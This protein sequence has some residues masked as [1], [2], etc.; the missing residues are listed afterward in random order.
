MSETEL[1]QVLP[2]ACIPCCDLWRFG[3]LTPNK[4]QAYKRLEA[5]GRLRIAHVTLYRQSGHTVVEYWSSL[6]HAWMLEELAACARESLKVQTEQQL[7]M[8]GENE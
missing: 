1:M 6:P 8:K 2:P 3:D 5:M 7:T 4:M